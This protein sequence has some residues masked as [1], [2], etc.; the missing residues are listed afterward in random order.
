MNFIENFK[1]AIFNIWLNKTRSFLTILGI[2]IGVSAVILLI[3]LGQG[4]RNQIVKEY[5]GLGSDLIF[6]TPGKVDYS[7]GM[8]FNPL[9][10]IGGSTLKKS[11]IESILKEAKS[12]KYA[13]PFSLVSGVVRAEN[14]KDSPLSI[15]VAT[16]PDFVKLRNLKVKEGRVFTNKEDDNKEKVCVLGKNTAEDLFKNESRERD[17]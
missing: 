13:V 6:V 15:T 11:D 3:A 2:I 10:T 1:V 5:E 17:R 8:R 14:G 12:V 9:A 4:A 7:Q 16:T